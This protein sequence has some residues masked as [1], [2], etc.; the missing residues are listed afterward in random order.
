MLWR[1]LLIPGACLGADRGGNTAGTGPP[2]GYRGEVTPA[3][4]RPAGTARRR[5]LS[6]ALLAAALLVLVEVT[7]LA[8]GHASPRR[9]WVIAA[10]GAPVV[11]PLAWRHR[12]PLAVLV[13]SGAATLA[14]MIDQGSPGPLAVGPLVALYTVATVSPRRISAGAA[15]VTLVGV[16]VGVAA[17][18]HGQ[19]NWEDFLLPWAVIAA[20]WLVGDNLRVRRAYVAE[21]EAKAARADADR[22]AEAERATSRERARIAREL[23]DVVVHRVSVIA[24][25]AAAARRMAPR[26]DRAADTQQA[27][28]DVEATAR[29]ALSE[30]RQLLG[31]L[32]HNGDPLALA[33]A[34]GLD[35][36]GELLDDVRRA[37][38]PVQARTEGHPVTLPPAVDLSAYRIVQEALTNVIK[39]AGCPP[40]TVTI[41]YTAQDLR[42]DVANGPAAGHAT[43]TSP[44]P[45]HGLAGMRERVAMF[46]GDLDA[47]PSPG[48]GF[49]VCARIPLETAS[50]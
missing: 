3:A 26:S 12:V 29:Q 19:L 17:G 47:G 25:Q 21:L 43:R 42:I 37:G 22:A 41:G 50:R 2:G 11:I 14:I 5:W 1:R 23:H 48:G 49:T 15:A 9:V 16:T 27:L 6:D 36:L 4:G 31:V 40:T 18:H 10:V 7:I 33:P 32:R 46:G 35:Q 45:G 44:G 28:T 34:P 8:K 38:L 20:A 39:H 30:L 13:V 24:V